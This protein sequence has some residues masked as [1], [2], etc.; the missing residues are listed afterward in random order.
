[1]STKYLATAEKEK[2]KKHPQTCPE[3]RSCFTPMVDS[4][5]IIPG[6]EA[7]EAQ[8]HPASMLRNNLKREYSEMRGFVRARMSLAIVI[9]NTIP[10]QG[11]RD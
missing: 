4:T 9:S 2:K 5:Y 7:I 11:D 3:R 1:M 8:R 6:T 10:L